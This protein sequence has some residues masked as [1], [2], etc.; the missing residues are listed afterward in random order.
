MCTLAAVALII[1]RPTL[2]VSKLIYPTYGH[3]NLIV[4]Q[5]A[6]RELTGRTVKKTADVARTRNFVMLRM[7]IVPAAVKRG[8]RQ[9]FA[10]R[11]YVSGTQARTQARTHACTHVSVFWSFTVINNANS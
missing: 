1:D 10:K 4:L 8:T 5:T 6:T 3:F 9:L 11:T 2:F 7:E